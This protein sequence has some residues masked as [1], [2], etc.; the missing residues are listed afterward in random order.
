[1]PLQPL[2]GFTVGVT[3][4][5]RAS[6][7]AELLRR[8]GA[9]VLDCPTIATAYLGSD[10]R[11]RGATTTLLESP[12]TVLVVTTGIGIR[13]WIEAAQS[14]G[15]DHALLDALAGARVV[16]RGPKAAAAAQALGLAVAATASDERMTGVRDLLDDLGPGDHVAVQSFGDDA[17]D[18]EEL[19]QRS[20]VRLTTVPVYRWQ[21]PSDVRPAR[22]LVRAVLD[23]RVHAV[24]FTSAPAVRNLFTIADEDASADDL[25]TALNATTVVAC[26]G[27]ACAEAA[28]AVGIT[29]PLWPEVGR[30][31]L[32]VR[33][34]SERLQATRS[35]M[36]L[37]GTTVEV[38]GRAMLVGDE[39][40]ELTWRE[41]DVFAA[42]A[43][44][45]GGLV[46]PAT[47]LRT[48]WGSAAADEHVVGVTVGRLRRKLGGSG[49]SVRTVPRR[50]Y[51]L[52]VTRR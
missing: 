34:L 50:G 12:P 48:V 15:L 46:S 43:E 38:Q 16:A 8:R 25:R 33:L 45:N 11:L 4:D 29:E 20:D 14:W 7:Q 31:G 27:P 9:R 41:A 52:E 24:T 22:Q 19:L 37:A 13:A 2:E 32:M 6:E 35:V 30:L 39:H 47:L 44:R 21:Q 28:L 23:G 5:R 36:E 3:A 26:V 40:V 10:E 17:S 51:R 1:M 42:L 18:A 49:A